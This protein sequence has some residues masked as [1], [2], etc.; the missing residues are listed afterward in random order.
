[1]YEDLF[2]Q[3]ERCLRPPSWG[4][5]CDIKAIYTS[6]KNIFSGLQFHR[7]HYA[8]IRLAV[9]ASKTREMS[10]NSKRIW[11]YSSS[12][13]SKV[14]DLGVNGKPILC[15]FLLVINSNFGRISYY[16]RD[17]DA[18][19]CKI[20]FFQPH[21]CLTPPS[22]GTPCNINI[23]NTSPKSTFTDNFVAYSIYRSIYIRLAVIASETREM[24]RNSKWFC[25]YSSSRSSKVIDLGVNGKPISHCNFGHICY[26]FRDIHA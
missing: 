19:S 9:I 8:D 15:D 7:W 5:P 12:R 6:L 22:E 13:S 25:P 14:I 20:V 24:S 26:R 21:R 3:S 18:F 11:P 2:L 16:F 23:I 17:I 4:T 10:R 1:M